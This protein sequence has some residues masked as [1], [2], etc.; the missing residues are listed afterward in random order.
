M[1]PAGA[2]SLEGGRPFLEVFAPR[3]YHAHQQV[4]D[5]AQAT[6][7]FVYLTSQGEIIEYDGSRWRGVEVPTSWVRKLAADDSGRV[8]LSGVDE[9]GW[10]EPGPDG[11]TSYHSLVDRLPAECRPLG[12][13]WTAHW[14]E[15][16]VWFATD[17]QVLRW[18]N[19]Q[20]DHWTFTSAPM[21]RLRMGG[22][23]LWLARRGDGL[24]RW[25][26]N[27]WKV[28]SRVPELTDHAVNLIIDEWSGGTT[29]LGTDEGRLWKMDGTGAVTAF[30]PEQMPVPS[31]ITGGARLR[32]RLIAITTND[33]G[34]LVLDAH[35]NFVEQLTADDGM[36]SASA[37]GVTEDREGG[38]WVGTSMG[39]ARIEL[40]SPYTFFGRESGKGSTVVLSLIRDHGVLYVGSEE[41]VRRLVP[42]PGGKAHFELVPG[43]RLRVFNLTPF[44]DGLLVGTDAGLARIYDGR[45]R[46]EVK[47][48]VPVLGLGRS[49][50]DPKRIFIGF[51]GTISTFRRGDKGEWIDE[52]TIA[53]FQGEARTLIETAEGCLW[54][55]T[56][57][58]GFARIT[59]GPGQ[60]WQKASVEYF[61]SGHGLPEELGW[62][63]ILPG[64]GGP[65]FTTAQGV[66]AFDTATRTFRPTP[67]FAAAHKDG[68]YTF[69][70]V[71]TNKD[72][73]WAQIAGSADPVDL[74]RPAIGRLVRGGDNLWKWLPLPDR[75]VKQIGYFGAYEMLVEPG[76]LWLS[77]QSSIVRID[78]GRL[79]EAPSPAV[80]PYVWRR[81]ARAGGAALALNSKHISIPYSTIPLQL[82]F[83][84]P[85]YSAGRSAEFAYKLRGFS[86]DWSDWK[87]KPEIELTGLPSGSYVLEVKARDTPKDAASPLTLAFQVTPPWYWSAA[88][89]FAYTLAT[90]AAVFGMVQWRLAALR[91]AKA[92]LE[93]LVSERTHDLNEATQ[94]AETASRA[95]TLF[96]ANVSH[97][98]RTPL[99]AILGYSQL[100][101][102]DRSLTPDARDRLR[103]VGASG[104]HLLRLINEV[105]DLSKIEAGKQELR[106][107]AFNLGMLLDEV[108]DAQGTRA[109]LKGLSLRRTDCAGVPAVVQGDAS[110]LRQILENLLG[111]AVKFT[112][113]GEVGVSIEPLEG[114]RYRFTVTDTGPGIAANELARLFQPFQQGG[115][116]SAN[117]ERG[118]GLGLAISQRLVSLMGGEIRVSSEVGKGSRFWFEVKLP[119]VRASKSPFPI[120]PP[121]PTNL[122]GRGRRVL[123]V[124]DVAVN[125]DLVR[126]LLEPLG[127]NVDLAATAEEALGKL[128]AQPYDLLVL[129]LRLPGMSGLDL[130]RRLRA[131]KA[132]AKLPILAASASTLGQDPQDSFDAG[133]ND[134]IGK[135]FLAEDLIQ[136][137][138]RLLDP[139]SDS[140]ATSEET[141]A[142]SGPIDRAILKD[143]FAAAQEGDV[144]KVRQGLQRLRAKGASGQ[145][146]VDIE[147]CVQNF[148][149]DAVAALAS[150]YLKDVSTAE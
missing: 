20:F 49:I 60:T 140:P 69:P 122:K 63:R 106:L 135:P 115:E 42:A 67:A 116:T 105:L 66:F 112:S 68:L 25:D 95:K 107:E 98:L 27:E 118:T 2:Q 36:P 150:A 84:Q 87:T 65:W 146:L 141:V 78:T 19:N 79:D 8:W 82:E 61:K 109:Y 47:T 41:G 99:H 121:Q 17:Q 35:G 127:F 129:D 59:Q 3:D 23:F 31:R 54:V 126:E 124:D 138:A 16:S 7:G 142:V 53:A 33:Q 76:V 10:C 92:R 55:G 86:N 21:Q 40:G 11:A 139:A 85:G 1:R 123:A 94:R 83:A 145:I 29:L 133:C 100:L 4:F 74:E 137:V 57:Q 9:L 39:V 143:I 89:L 45:E 130:A 90:I 50:S 72:E 103:I 6:S 64:A 62:V 131:E 5:V 15:Q 56:T 52:G 128:A 30:E 134:F 111:N 13:V 101:E 88:M 75:I 46:L 102:N 149:V 26:T 37:Y 136:K 114:D 44:D 144:L 147:K 18:R 108:V 14:F 22:K 51:P 28:V 24:Y 117:L 104:R 34:V 32:S 113:K 125:R 73:I 38:V 97:E 70:I 120:Q 48:P 132:T 58:R 43:G 12:T 71:G 148:D 93:A 119:T 91:T 96:L 77:G 80:F 110:K 81:V